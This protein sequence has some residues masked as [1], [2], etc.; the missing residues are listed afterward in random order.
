MVLIPLILGVFSA[1]ADFADVRCVLR[2]IDFDRNLVEYRLSSPREDVVKIVPY[3]GDI[4]NP[5][6]KYFW[7]LTDSLGNPGYYSPQAARTNRWCGVTSPMTS[8]SFVEVGG[9]RSSVFKSWIPDSSDFFTMFDT[10]HQTRRLR[11]VI[12]SN[13]F[14]VTQYL[15]DAQR[16]NWPNLSSDL[17]GSFRRWRPFATVCQD[18]FVQGS[19]RKERRFDGSCSQGPCLDSTRRFFQR[20]RGNPMPSSNFWKYSERLLAI[21]S[22]RDSTNRYEPQSHPLWQKQFHDLHRY[23]FESLPVDP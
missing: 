1:A 12:V 9:G 5:P 21:Y 14:E 20:I 2:S 13:P 7:I 4:M 11:M 23:F 8:E 17:W 6:V 18:I 19:I 16:R 3:K 10:T 15:D 22:L